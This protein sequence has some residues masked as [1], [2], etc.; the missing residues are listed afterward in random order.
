VRVEDV[1]ELYYLAPI[2]SVPSIL[3][4]GILSHNRAAK[5]PHVDISMAVIQDRR[6]KKS[7]PGGLRLHDYANLYFNARNKMMSKK[8]PEHDRICVLCVS[9][10]VLHLPGA[11]VADQNASSD[12]ALFLQSPAGL[13]KLHEQEVFVRSWKCAGDQIREWILGSIVCAELLIPHRVDPTFIQ[14]AYVLD[15]SAARTFTAMQTR[16]ECRPNA[17]MFLR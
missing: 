4:H 17:D 7:V 6:A 15:S 13:Q 12:Y 8:R 5:L 2:Q 9:P 14:R 1:K 10:E 16:V 3:E 11:V